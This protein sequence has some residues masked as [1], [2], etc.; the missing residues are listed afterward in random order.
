MNKKDRKMGKNGKNKKFVQIL[1]T[2]RWLLLIII[3][4]VTATMALFLNRQYE[5]H[6]SKKLVE[7]LSID[8]EDEKINWANYP[9]TN[10]V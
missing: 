3:I 2:S 8:N 7:P 5:D 10:V 6:T 4:V 1:F 9:T